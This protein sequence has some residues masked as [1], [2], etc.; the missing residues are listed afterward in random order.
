MG[1]NRMKTS[2][3]LFRNEFATITFRH[4]LYNLQLPLAEACLLLGTVAAIRREK[5]S[6][7]IGC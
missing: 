7:I 1:I 3:K 2:K 5:E 6:Y 4:Q